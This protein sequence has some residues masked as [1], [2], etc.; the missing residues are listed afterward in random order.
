MSDNNNNEKEEPEAK[1]L[2][3]S[4]P[5]LCIMVGADGDTKEYHYHSQ[6]MASHS[7]Y[8]D[9]T[10]ATPMKESQSLRL[11]FPDIT[12]V[13]WNLMMKYLDPLQ[14]RSLDMEHAMKLA[15]YY[16]KYSFT[17]GLRVCDDVLTG[18][19]KSNCGKQ[20]IVQHLNAK[21]NPDLDTLISIFLLANDAN[22]QET[23][24][25]AC[26]YFR[27][28]LTANCIF[29]YGRVIFTREQ[30][31]KLAPLIV[32]KKLLKSNYTGGWTD[33]EIMN[34]STYSL[35]SH[36]YTCH[37]FCQHLSFSCMYSVSRILCS[38]Q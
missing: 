4:E 5:D 16:D 10:L 13:K 15:P 24:K 11:N 12:P 36:A 20:N 28:V 14:A 33:E 18:I 8:I 19:F 32:E 21:P 25:H 34:P 27:E 9:T 1:R 6:V 2:R 7:S 17:S 22:L 38:F 37:K 29:R 31:Q 3:S 30:I 35:S 26:E 23:M